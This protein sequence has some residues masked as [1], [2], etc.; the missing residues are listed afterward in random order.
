MRER[1]PSSDY[2]FPADHGGLLSNRA[3]SRSSTGN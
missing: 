1:H 3:G 2:L